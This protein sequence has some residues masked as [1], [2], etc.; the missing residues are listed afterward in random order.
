MFHS[1]Q[2]RRLGTSIETNNLAGK[3]TEK[4]RGGTQLELRIRS[5]SYL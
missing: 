2:C 3:T 5:Y 4:N 1:R